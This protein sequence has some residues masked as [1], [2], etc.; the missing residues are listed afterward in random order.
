MG[1]PPVKNSGV[2][3]LRVSLDT[4]SEIVDMATE[5]GLTMSQLILN[6]VAY[7]AAAPTGPGGGA[8]LSLRDHRFIFLDEDEGETTFI[9]VPKSLSREA[10]RRAL[11]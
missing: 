2:I 6:A 1:R 7:Y 11:R 8:P 10:L 5:F 9:C 4:K 3:A